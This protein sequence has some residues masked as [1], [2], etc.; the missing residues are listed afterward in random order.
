MAHIITECSA[1][2]AVLSCIIN[3]APAGNAQQPINVINP[4]D[5]S[6][7]AKVAECGQADA[8]AAVDAAAKAFP[9]LT[10]GGG[11]LGPAAQVV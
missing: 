10:H 4:F 6:L 5:G 9:E 11:A 2:P 1:E 3:G 8:K 7:L